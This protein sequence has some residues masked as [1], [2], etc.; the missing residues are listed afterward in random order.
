MQ[1]LQ[2]TMGKVIRRERR[3]RK[4]TRRVLAERSAISVVYLG[5]IERGQKYPSALVLERLAKALDLDIPDLLE[6]MA[7]E[8]RG[9]PVPRM[10][11]GFL[12]PEAQPAA[13]RT[14]PTG[15]VISMLVA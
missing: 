4:M 5:E 7:E 8:M 11:I 14:T 2:L 1:D 3:G 12:L 6:C 10:A 15:K 13:S 9:V